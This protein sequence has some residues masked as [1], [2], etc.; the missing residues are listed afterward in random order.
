[1]INFDI[2]KIL[3]SRV[4][5]MHFTHIKNLA[6]CVKHSQTILPSWV[7]IVS[8]KCF[9]I[10]EGYRLK[11]CWIRGNYQ[12]EFYNWSLFAWWLLKI[13]H[14]MFQKGLKQLISSTMMQIIQS[15]SNFVC[16]MSRTFEEISEN[17][18]FGRGS[19]P[20]P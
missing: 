17:P 13:L 6:I 16:H 1:M 11:S 10:A 4:Q 14:F 2:L 12:L 20:F 15:F 7:C 18:N 3:I 19:Y 9:Q 8:L 5:K